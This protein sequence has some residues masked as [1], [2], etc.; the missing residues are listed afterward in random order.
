MTNLRS[1]LIISTGFLP[2]LMAFCAAETYHLDA[3]NQWQNTDSSEEGR[4]LLSAAKL[5]QQ[6]MSGSSNEALAALEQL[7]QEFPDL[8]G[9]QFDAYIEAEL[10][11][12]QEQWYKAA[13]MYTRFAD[14]W[15]D[16]P[17]QSAALE[18]VYSI[19]TAYLQGQKRVYI[20]VL[21]L[22]AFD[23][24]AE[25]MH[26]LADRAGNAPIASRALTTLAE[27]QEKKEKYL[28]A[29]Q[30]WAEIADRWPTGPEGQ[31]ALL[32]MGQALHASYDG[33]E[34][35]ASVLESARTYFEDF[36]SR[37]GKEKAGEFEIPEKLALIN[38]QLAYKVYQMGFYYERTGSMEAAEMYYN[39]VLNEWPDSDA[40][41]MATARFSENAAPAAKSTVRR[42]AFN[43]VS[44]F[45]DRWFG[46][47]PLFGSDSNDNS[48][49][50]KGQ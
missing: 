21:K 48:T 28:D 36:I 42:K 41:K 50:D 9:E 25:L 6:L 33:T 17:L 46:L 3:D 2:A 15:P 16:S 12:A 38:E 39:K 29:Y 26:D 13:T 8:A 19:A 14:T 43:G 35:D 5:K 32:R 23:T 4:Y 34:Y 27:N 30:T 31:Q 11:Y 37:Y 20:K 22:P 18:R 45:L 49:L 47:E 40:A 7:K 24:G 1:L 10:Y 44:T